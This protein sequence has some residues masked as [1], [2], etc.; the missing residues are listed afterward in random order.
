MGL[1]ELEKK[2]TKFKNFDIKSRNN[3]K[4]SD[5]KAAKLGTPKNPAL[6]VVK[7]DEKREEMRK[8]FKE[9]GW[10]ERTK[11][12]PN[13][14]EDLK[15]LERLMVIGET[16]VNEINLGRNEPCFCGSGKKYKKCCL[17]K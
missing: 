6:L 8:L 15:D 1:K 17:N 16:K 7:T 13:L 12:K 11:V 9:K 4:F 10:S 2:A 3:S 14:D 5:K